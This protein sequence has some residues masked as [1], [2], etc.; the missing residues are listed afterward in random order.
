M[1]VKIVNT[2]DKKFIGYVFDDKDNPI[3]LGDVKVFWDKRIDVS[4]EE[5]IFRNSNYIIETI[6][7][8]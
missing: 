4:L 3:L 7:I 5:V 8:K 2:T 1:K 6:K